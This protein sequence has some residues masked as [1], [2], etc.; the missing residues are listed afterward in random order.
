MHSRGCGLSPMSFAHEIPPRSLVILGK[1]IPKRSRRGGCFLVPS[2]P[3]EGTDSSIHQIVASPL[4]APLLQSP[5][6]S[7]V[8]LRREGPLGHPPG[9]KSSF[10]PRRRSLPR[11][12]LDLGRVLMEAHRLIRF[13][14][15]RQCLGLRQRSCPRPLGSL[16]RLHCIVVLFCL[17]SDVSSQSWCGVRNWRRL[18]GIGVIGLSSALLG[19]QSTGGSFQTN[20]P[21]YNKLVAE[22]PS[23]S[24]SREPSCLD[25]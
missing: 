9:S 18:S 10:F 24:A 22:C 11:A 19:V 15:A 4:A 6:A 16:G 2:Q 25:H 1:F 5:S 3:I 20:G 17:S 14:S 8:S 13:R 23:V 12:R 21:S 7:L